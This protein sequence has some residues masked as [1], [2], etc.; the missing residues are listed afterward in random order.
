MMSI[1]ATLDIQSNDM[2]EDRVVE[3]KAHLL[4]MAA[5]KVPN[6]ATRRQRK[7]I[8]Q[9]L[10]SPRTMDNIGTASGS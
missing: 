10:F 7:E 1:V 8:Y 9:L 6:M 3:T 2:C 5:Q 4:F